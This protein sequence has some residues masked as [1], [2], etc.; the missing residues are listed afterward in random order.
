[1]AYLNLWNFYMKNRELFFSIRPLECRLKSGFEI[2]GWARNRPST[3]GNQLSIM[4]CM[5][6]ESPFLFRVHCGAVGE[7]YSIEGID[8][9]GEAGL[10]PG[11][12]GGHLL[13]HA[14]RGHGAGGGGSADQHHHGTITRHDP[15]TPR[16]KRKES[17]RIH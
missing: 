15:G 3:E 2:I 6:V 10:E 12:N 14:V 17:V 1:M 4:K 13:F 9:C 11:S 8:P 5:L 16:E 7:L